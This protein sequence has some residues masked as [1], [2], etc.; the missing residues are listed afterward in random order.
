MQAWLKKDPASF[1]P[2]YECG[3]SWTA[4][5]WAEGFLQAVA[6]DPQAWAKLRASEPALLLP[7]QRKGANWAGK[8]PAAVIAINA[9]WH[10]PQPKSAKVGRN[11]PCP[12]GSG[13]KHKKC[14][15]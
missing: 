12:C 13:K 14:C 1:E 9:Y 3:G 6:L 8:I 10:A 15:A 2:I 4:E 11:D 5:A 7:F